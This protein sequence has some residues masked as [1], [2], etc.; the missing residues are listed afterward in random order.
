MLHDRPTSVELVEAI[1]EFLES[2]VLASLDGRVGFHTRVAI[3]SLAQVRRE[4][5]AG[6]Q[7]LAEHE[8]RLAALGQRDQAEFALSIRDG[9]LD[10]RMP[11][12]YA[13]VLADVTAKLA[14]ANPRYLDSAEPI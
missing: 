6:E 13:A 14:V 1:R 12:V 2:E 10:D 11:E 5:E 3:N 8:Q 9:N 7:P 4:L